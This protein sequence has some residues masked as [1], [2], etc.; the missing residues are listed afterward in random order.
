MKFS[1]D[2]INL[3]GVKV[4]FSDFNTFLDNSVLIADYM[5]RYLCYYGNKVYI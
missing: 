4:F 2:I 1:V 5:F 3:L